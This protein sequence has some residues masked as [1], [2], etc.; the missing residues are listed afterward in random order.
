V[1]QRARALEILAGMKTALAGRRVLVTGAA[2]M[3]GSEFVSVLQAGGA[4]VVR[5]SRPALD[6]DRPELF[7]DF[8]RANAASA[9]IHCAAETNVDACESDPEMASRRNCEVTCAVAEIARE[10]G[11]QIVFVSS[12]G[13][14]D[15][16]KIGPYDERDKPSPC[17]VYARSKVAA[18]EVLIAKFPEALIVRAG[19]LFGGEPSQKKNFVAARWREAQGKEE[20]VSASDKMG[21][22]TWTRDLV[23]QVLY[24]MMVNA[25]GIFHTVNAGSTSRAGYVAEIMRLCGLPTRVKPVSSGEFQRN[26]PVPD[27]E[28]LVSVRVAEYGITPRRW[29]DALAEYLASREGNFSN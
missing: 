24:L 15:G 9:V 8:L 13:V 16:R 18:E 25:G 29:Q 4:E 21:T 1:G 27:N 7:R 10:L 14:F 19:W 2:G 28:A 5:A 6:L 17:T 22:P 20:I 12:S 26:A 3:L 23:E 11:A